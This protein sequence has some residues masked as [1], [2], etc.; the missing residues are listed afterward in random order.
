MKHLIIDI[1]KCIGCGLCKQVCIRD[2]IEIIN[3]K[4]VDVESNCFDCG[5][6]STLCPTNAIMIKAYSN[7]TSRIEEYDSDDIVVNIFFHNAEFSM[8]CTVFIYSIDKTGYIFFIIFGI[9]KY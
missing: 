2:N 7:Q 1:D 5:Q 6:C 9:G 4:A 3:N 8:P